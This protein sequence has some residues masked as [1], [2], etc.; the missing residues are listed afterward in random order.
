[1]CGFTLAVSRFQ[2]F[3]SRRNNRRLSP[4]VWSGVLFEASRKENHLLTDL[5]WMFLDIGHVW[6]NV[7]SPQLL[8]KP[9]LS[10]HIIYQMILWAPVLS[11]TA[12]NGIVIYSP[13]SNP[14]DFFLKK[15]LKNCGPIYCNCIGKIDF[16]FVLFFAILVFFVIF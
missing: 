2:Y 6:S 9:N 7:S 1:M 8:W 12:F 11:I 14:Y 4:Q 16:C 10:S 3:I 5:Q 15:F 13:S